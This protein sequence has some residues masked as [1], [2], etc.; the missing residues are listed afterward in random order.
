MSEFNR[1]SYFKLLNLEAINPMNDSFKVIIIIYIILFK[2]N[3]IYSVLNVIEK[4]NK[5]K[6]IK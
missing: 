4:L 2:T 1:I 3:I 6:I 5:L